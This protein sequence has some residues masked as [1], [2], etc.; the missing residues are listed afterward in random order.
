ME[1]TTLNVDGSKFGSSGCIGFGGVLCNS[2][3]TW[4]CG[5]WLIGIS[6]NLHAELLTI[7]HGLKL[8]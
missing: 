3:G 5:F 6:N 2:D 7:I 4:L 8:S 1:A